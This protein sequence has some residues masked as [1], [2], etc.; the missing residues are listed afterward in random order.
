MSKCPK[1][2]GEFGRKTI[3]LPSESALTRSSRKMPKGKT[4]NLFSKGVGRLGGCHLSFIHRTHQ[5]PV[6][7]QLQA[8][9]EGGLCV[10]TC[11]GFEDVQVF[12]F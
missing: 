3:S 1:M 2:S 9:S 5:V 10:C 8:G 11:A 4:M 12:F 6:N 7:N